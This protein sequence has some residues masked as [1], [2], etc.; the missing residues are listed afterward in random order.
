MIVTCILGSPHG[1]KGN[2][3]VLATWLLWEAELD[4][5]RITGVSLSD[6][7]ARPCQGLRYLRR[8]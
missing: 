8:S 1:I 6:C 7:A 3:A 5:A 4:G 2:T